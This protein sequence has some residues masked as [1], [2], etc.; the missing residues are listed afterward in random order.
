[1]PMLHA[2]ARSCHALRA[3]LRD[4][5]GLIGPQRRLPA[6]FTA[7]MAHGLE[8]LRRVGREMRSESFDII[9]AA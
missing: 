9:S 5:L 1:M 4:S 6:L 7:G 2:L 3:A 8:E